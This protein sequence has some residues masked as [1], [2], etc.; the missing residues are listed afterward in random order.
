MNLNN[1]VEELAKTT[2]FSKADIASSMLSRAEKGLPLDLQY[3]AEETPPDPQDE[4]GNGDGGE[5]KTPEQ[6]ELEKKIEAESDR[7]LASAKKKWEKEQETKIQEAI[8]TALAEKERLSKLSEKERKEE[9]LSTR[10]KEIADRLA[11]LERKELKADAIADLNEKGLPKEFADF[12]L[13]DNAEN[14]LKNINAF[15]EAFDKAVNETVKEKLRQDTP[16]AGGGAG[17]G[18]NSIAELRNKQDQQKNKAPD[19]WA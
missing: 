9:E 5:E 19:L 17:K 8:K 11:E 3:F 10:E 14:T 7:K 12:L 13:A 15:K 18:T 4:N 1:K 2:P 16:P 6:I